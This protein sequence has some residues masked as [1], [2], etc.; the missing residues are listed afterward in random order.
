MKTRVFLLFLLFSC[1]ILVL[2]QDSTAVSK[3]KPL[4]F[5]AY[6]EGYFAHDF[7][8]PANG[9]RP[10]FFD[11]FDRHGKF[12]LN[13]GFAKASYAKGAVRANLA[14]ESGTYIESNYAS[15]PGMLG[16]LLEANLGVRL[17][18]N[19]RWWL[20]AGVMPSHIGFE[21][22]L[23]KDNWALTYSMVTDNSPLYETGVK[24][25][26]STEKFNLEST[27]SYPII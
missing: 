5:S 19:G 23:G 11:H 22:N 6:A 17:D 9:D 13:F 18:R 25:A 12:S 26:Y 16:H 15:E 2:A 8:R 20:D 7:D 4:T 21:S 14:L 24:L 27:I 10:A 1:P 3:P